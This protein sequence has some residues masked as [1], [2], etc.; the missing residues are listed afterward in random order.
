MSIIRY[1]DY[2]PLPPLQPHEIRYLRESLGWSQAKLG[3]FLGKTKVTIHRWEQ[4]QFAPDEV[5]LGVLHRLWIEVFGEYEGPY[6]NMYAANTSAQAP[7]TQLHNDKL[8]TVAK[9]LLIGGVAFFLAKGLMIDE[10]EG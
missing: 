2:H 9:A 1:R 7:S 3:D 8:A 4:G 10:E 5:T 6:A